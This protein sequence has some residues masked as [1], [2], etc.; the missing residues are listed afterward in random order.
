MRLLTKDDI[1]KNRVNTIKQYYVLDYL[2]NNLNIDEFSLYLDR[3]NNI[4]VI[5]K[6]NK[7]LYFYYDN[8][9]KEVVYDEKLIFEKSN[10]LEL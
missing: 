9:K 4:K 5:D 7:V 1:S 2:K 3:N 6:D 8:T 10:D